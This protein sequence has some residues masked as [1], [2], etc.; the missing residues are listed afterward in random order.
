MISGDFAMNLAISKAQNAGC[1][2]VVVN[3]SNHFGIAGYYAIKAVKHDM[4]GI[5]MT[6]ANPTVAP[7]FAKQAMLGTNPIAFAMPTKTN[8]CF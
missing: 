6:N 2:V 4:I 1:G 5:A 3:N 8:Q 7:T